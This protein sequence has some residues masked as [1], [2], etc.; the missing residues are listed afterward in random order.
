MNIPC[1]QNIKDKYWE[2]Q[3]IAAGK[4]LAKENRGRN[5][6]NEEGSDQTNRN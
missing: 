6:G 1:T 5:V 2:K 4:Q 3:R